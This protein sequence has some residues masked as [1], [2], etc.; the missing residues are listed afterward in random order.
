MVIP[1]WGIPFGAASGGAPRALRAPGQGILEDISKIL[2]W[3]MGTEADFGINLQN[4]PAGG[5]ARGQGASPKL[6]SQFH[7]RRKILMFTLLERAGLAI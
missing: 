3:R 2:L 6:V 5:R 4:I 1:I 7:R